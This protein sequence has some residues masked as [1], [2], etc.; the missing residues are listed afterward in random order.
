[1]LRTGIGYGTL[2]DGTP[3][4]SRAVRRLACDAKIIPVL[5]GTKCCPLDIGRSARIVTPAMR[6]ALVLRDKGCRFPGCDRPASWT[7]A[8]HVIHGRDG[9][10]T[11]VGNL[12]LLCRAHHHKVHDAG[13]I[14]DILGDGQF[15]FRPPDPGPDGAPPRT[16]TATRRRYARAA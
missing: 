2:A 15:R 14:I 9:G 5:Y 6:K 10:P 4:P 8:H 3:I 11:A 16:A 13:W 12:I 7:D 1:M